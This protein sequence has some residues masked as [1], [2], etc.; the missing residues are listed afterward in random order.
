MLFTKNAHGALLAAC[1]RVTASAEAH[2]SLLYP[3]HGEIRLP[4]KRKKT[5]SAVLDNSKDNENV[6]M[7]GVLFQFGNKNKFPVAFQLYFNVAGSTDSSIYLRQK[8]GNSNGDW[9]DWSTWAVN[10]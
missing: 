3:L 6:S 10:K 9:G 2:G 1:W 8:A 7:Y 5:Q 4:E